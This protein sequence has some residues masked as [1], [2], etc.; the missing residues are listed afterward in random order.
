MRRSR[1][2]SRPWSAPLFTPTTLRH[3]RRRGATSRNEG[4]M[5]AMN[6]GIVAKSHLREAMPHLA[7][8]ESW[9]EARGVEPMFETA[10]AAL[11]PANPKRRLADKG[12]LVTRV[13]LI[14]VLGGDGTLLSG[15]GCI[16]SAQ[17]RV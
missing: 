4:T 16:P 5:P 14:V 13:D 2:S 10:T 3:G 12:E 11:M 6:V 9:L 1:R 15:P 8:I 17:G 7:E